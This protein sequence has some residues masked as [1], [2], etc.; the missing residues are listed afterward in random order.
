MIKER[1]T[2]L[3]C[4]ICAFNKSEAK[5]REQAKSIKAEVFDYCMVEGANTD[6]Y[7]SRH[8]RE[9]FWSA[10]TMMQTI[11]NAVAEDVYYAERFEPEW[12]GFVFAECEMKR[13]LEKNSSIKSSDWDK[14]LKGIEDIL[15]GKDPN[16][17]IA[18]VYKHYVEEYPWLEA[19]RM[20]DAELQECLSRDTDEEEAHYWLHNDFN[21]P[22][23]RICINILKSFYE[24]GEQQLVD[25]N[26]IN[27]Q[28]DDVILR[29]QESKDFRLWGK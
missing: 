16:A 15:S 28:L 10:R 11:F 18:L 12:N 20:T 1:F 3:Y 23:N 13:A 19:V 24:T 14:M 8:G 22:Y 4:R 2:S 9:N 17:D 29:A 21:R 6:N 26:Y 25:N 27:G 5:D 7:E